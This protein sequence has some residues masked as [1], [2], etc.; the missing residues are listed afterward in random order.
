[1]N[2]NLDEV[3]LILINYERCR[4]EVK[5]IPCRRYL[6]MLVTYCYYDETDGIRELKRLNNKDVKQLAITEET[7][8]NRA[9]H[10]TMRMFPPVFVKLEDK[11]HDL[12]EGIV[13]IDRGELEPEQQSP[14]Y[15]L[16]N[17]TDFYGASV[18]LYEDLLENLS[19]I[20]GS[21]FYIIPSSI[22]E[23]LVIF[24]GTTENNPEFL[25]DML[26][27]VNREVLT[28]DLILSDNIYHFCHKSKMISVL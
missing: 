12:L 10:N 20:T 22:H 17:R 18:L 16:G 5:D 26:H 13:G 15:Y 23:Y 28:P 9:L 27:T 19:E 25:T 7:L 3:F 1:M 2:I 14:L 6:D 21:G 8:Y 11:F 24:D 4:D